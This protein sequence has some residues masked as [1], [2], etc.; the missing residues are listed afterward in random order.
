MEISGQR[1][2]D[3][4]RG[5]RILRA[6]AELIAER[7]FQ[8][9]SLDDIGTAAGIVG[10]GVYRHFGSKSAILVELFERVVDRLIDDAAGVLRQEIEADRQL[11][12]LVDVQVQFTLSQR[13]LGRV[14]VQ[15]EHNLPA[16]DRRRLRRK[17]RDYIDLWEDALARARPGLAPSDTHALVNIAVGAIHSALRFQSDLDAGRGAPPKRAAHHPGHKNN[18]KKQNK[19]N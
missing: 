5:E 9:V 6:A 15:E 16:L 19:T 11:G 18:N 10:S 1:V 8:G 7:G 4:D 3:P 2:R 13:V 17:Q 12:M 14:Y